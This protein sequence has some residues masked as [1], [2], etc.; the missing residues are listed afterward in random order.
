MHEKRLD[1]RK[2]LVAYSFP[3]GLIITAALMPLDRIA[4][5]ATSP[6]YLSLI[7]L[8][9]LAIRPALELLTHPRNIWST[10]KPLLSFAVLSV[11][12]G[13]I[14]S[15]FMSIDKAATYSALVLLLFVS[16]RAWFMAVFTGSSDLSVFENAVLIVSVPV[17]LFG[18]YQF[19]ADVLGLSQAFTFLIPRYSSVATYSFPRIQST[20]LE[21]LYLA[22]YLMLPIGILAVRA[23]KRS[24]LKRELLLLIGLFVAFFITNSRGAILGLLLALFI[25]AVSIRNRKWLGII[26]CSILASLVI[27]T[28]FVGF[29]GQ[30]HRKNSVGSFATHAIDLGDESAR[31][32]YDLWPKSIDIFLNHPIT[33]VGFYNSRHAIHPELPASTPIN[34]LQPLNNDYLAYLAETGLVG[35]LLILPLA[36]LVIKRIW[37]VIKYRFVHPSS[38]YAFAFIGMAFQANAFH[39]ILLLRTWVVIALL[40]AGQR[41][42]Q[43]A[44]S[45]KV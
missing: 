45:I 20:A 28:A 5:L 2:H 35:I 9:L 15:S 34:K 3:A 32:R 21:P 27:V 4:N 40:L 11:L 22:H 42:I 13:A 30:V 29:A 16:A 10:L 41:I 12:I 36:F 26:I 6:P 1:I 23:A 37:T 33:G 7:A 24:L 43:D 25:A 14:L 38:P 19:I 18:F 44:N 31:T 39:S 17:I 8:I